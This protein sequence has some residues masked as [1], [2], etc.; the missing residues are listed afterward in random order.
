MAGAELR[1]YKPKLQDVDYTGDSQT[2]QVYD[3]IR[4]AT[5]KNPDAILRLLD[6]KRISGSTQRHSWVGLD[7][8]EAVQRWKDEP[9]YGLY[10]QVFQ[11]SENSTD[12]VSFPYVLLKN[13]RGRVNETSWDN[14]QPILLTYHASK[15][16]S[17]E[18][19]PLLRSKRGA[20]RHHR[21]KNHNRQK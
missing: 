4:P 17:K 5:R 16:N 8:I 6:T 9:N 12:A 7:V 1:L 15:P 20:L 14:Q 21:R 11:E 18:N 10:V 13:T 2:V 19:M 3:I